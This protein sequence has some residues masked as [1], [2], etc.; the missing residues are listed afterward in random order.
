MSRVQESVWRNTETHLLG[1]NKHIEMILNTFDSLDL[2]NIY[3]CKTLLLRISLP[4][5]KFKRNGVITPLT[6]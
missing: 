6:S 5:E 4:Q 3:I 1:N 2:S